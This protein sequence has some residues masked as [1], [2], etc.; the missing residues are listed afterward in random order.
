MGNLK[1]PNIVELTQWFETEKR[2]YLIMELAK[3]GAHSANSEV[4]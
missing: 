2:I 4:Y 1:H 3:D